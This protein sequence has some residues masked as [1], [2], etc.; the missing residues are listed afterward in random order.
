MCIRDRPLSAIQWQWLW[1]EAAAILIGTCAGALPLLI[2]GWRTTTP[3]L[4]EALDVF[5]VALSV[6][7]L[8]AIAHLVAAM[9]SHPVVW[10]VAPLVC[11]LVTTIPMTVNEDALANTGRSS[12]TFAWS[13]GMIEPTGDHVV[14]GEA[15]V[16]RALFFLVVTASCLS[17]IHI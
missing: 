12:V 10:I 2:K 14:T 5:V 4:F 3:T 16:C 9:I 11:L 17:L 1:R 15:V 13:L 8:L 6:V 7:A